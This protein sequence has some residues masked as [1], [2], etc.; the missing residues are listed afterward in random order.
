MGALLSRY[1]WR[2]NPALKGPT[3]S[4]TAGIAGWMVLP[5]LQALMS[6]PVL[7]FV[8][9]EWADSVGDRASFDAIS[10]T[11]RGLVIATLLLV[12]AM[13]PAA[14]TQLALLFRK[15]SS[16]PL[17]FIL[18]K[19]GYIALGLLSVIIVARGTDSKATHQGIG[20]LIGT[21]FSAAIW[22][23]YVLVS[24]RV[25]ATFV[26]DSHGGYPRPD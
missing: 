5:V 23:A 25:R 6:L 21:V 20:E 1:L 8:I 9:V 2:L 10:A 16:F 14:I 22:I 24:E 26:R 11:T 7:I 4:A 12:G 3:A 15:R 17:T 19:A 18:M 13:I